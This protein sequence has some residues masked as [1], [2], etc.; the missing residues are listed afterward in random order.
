MF[1]VVVFH[2]D[3]FCTV[4]PFAADQET[5]D[6][7]TWQCT[8]GFRD[9][10]CPGCDAGDHDGHTID[11]KIYDQHGADVTEEMMPAWAKGEL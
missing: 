4:L 6:E 3:E 5:I 11:F 8:A 9:D 7:T 1:A 2:D 10:D